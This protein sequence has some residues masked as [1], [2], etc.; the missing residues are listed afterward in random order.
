MHGLIIEFFATFLIY[1]LFLGLIS[2]WFIDGKIKKEQVLHA[3]LAAVLGAL[4]SSLIKL[5][6]P[7]DRPFVVNG[8]ETNVLIAPKDGAFPSNHT[9]VAFAVAVTVF[10]HD[11]KV[12]LYFLVTATMI[13]IARV[14]ANVHYPIDIVGGV[15]VGTLAAILIDKTHLFKLFKK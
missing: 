13:G 15:V 1:F 11:K 2:L 8:L 10:L 3:L 5:M 6:F 9:T 12:G 14:I 4:I 7:I